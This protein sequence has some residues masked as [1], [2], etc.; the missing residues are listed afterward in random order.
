M[1]LEH[2]SNKSNA[3]CILQ[4]KIVYVQSPSLLQSSRRSSSQQTRNMPKLRWMH[5]NWKQMTQRE[6]WTGSSKEK[7]WARQTWRSKRNIWT[8]HP[9]LN[10]NN[11]K[12]N[13]HSE[14]LALKYL[15]KSPQSP[16]DVKYQNVYPQECERER[17]HCQNITEVDLEPRT[18]NCDDHRKQIPDD[19][20]SMKVRLKL[21]D[22]NV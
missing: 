11:W 5:S 13:L 2:H 16:P 21:V 18:A 1:V 10:G 17:S 3:T 8:F 12:N 4:M 22:E 14:M 19:T 6:C 15:D 20:F 7:P 9:M